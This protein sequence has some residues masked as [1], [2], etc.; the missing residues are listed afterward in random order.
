[1]GTNRTKNK[2][3][4]ILTFEM[5]LTRPNMFENRKMFNAI[6]AREK[7]WVAF[8]FFFFLSGESLMTGHIVFGFKFGS[9]VLIAPEALVRV[10]LIQGSSTF[11]I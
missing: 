11:M 4:N 1:M 8:F 9:I 6:H 5:P 10:N 7:R 2:K 3:K